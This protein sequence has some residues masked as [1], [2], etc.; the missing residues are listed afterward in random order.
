[1]S[2][3]IACTDNEPLW[4]ATS[5]SPGIFY[6]PMTLSNKRTQELLALSPRAESIATKM[7]NLCERLGTGTFWNKELNRLEIS[8]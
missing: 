2:E 3:I 6:V 8:L 7:D 5:T 4:E 1:L